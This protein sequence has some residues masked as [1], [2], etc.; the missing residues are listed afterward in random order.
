METGSDQEGAEA[1]VSRSPAVASPSTSPSSKR[2]RVAA[3]AGP[4]GQ[5]RE[6]D[7]AD[8]A[9]TASTAPPSMTVITSTSVSQKPASADGAL[10]T[11][12]APPS[13]TITTST[14]VTLATATSTAAVAPVAPPWGGIEGAAISSRERNRAAVMSSRELMESVLRFIAGGSREARENVGRAAAVCRVWREAAYGEEVWGRMAAEV[15]PVLGAGARGLGRDGREYVVEFG[16]CLMERRVIFAETWWEGLR[17]HIEVWDEGDGLRMLSVEGRLGLEK[18]DHYISLGVTGEDRC[19][20]VGPAFSAASRDPEGQWFD[21]IEDYLS[22]PA[23][24][25][26][27][28]RLCTRAVVRDVRSG[29]RALLWESGRSHAWTSFDEDLAD[30]GPLAP[31][32]PTRSMYV[33]THVATDRNILS[34]PCGDAAFEMWT[35][36]YVRPEAGQVGATE[37]ARLYR[38]VGGDEERYGQHD[39]IAR[40]YMRTDDSAALGRFVWS[41]LS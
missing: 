41:L 27:P 17:L 4:D 11:P 19:E 21:D 29:R 40:I 39:S 6:P 34:P 15:L 37:R 8:R 36:L 3:P 20:V 9:L 28:S 16:R 35:S 30:D 25:E 31:F 2:T 38:F 5:G 7:S 26:I 22:R 24:D 12:T 33:G 13:M 10:T 1:G 32:L 23:G 14:S 18:S